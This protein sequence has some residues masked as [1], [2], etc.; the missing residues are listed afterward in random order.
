MLAG[1]GE[2]KENEQFS[3]ICPLAENCQMSLVRS[4]VRWH[5]EIKT[6]WKKYE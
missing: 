4:E 6:S 5:R 3:Y 1:G 2:N